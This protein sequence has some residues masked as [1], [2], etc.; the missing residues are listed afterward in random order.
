ML[1]YKASYQ[2]LTIMLYILKIYY[3]KCLNIFYIY[4]CYIVFNIDQ[5]KDMPN[6]LTRLSFFKL[7]GPDTIQHF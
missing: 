4:P 5:P 2:L 3:F 1:T 6:N 7:Y